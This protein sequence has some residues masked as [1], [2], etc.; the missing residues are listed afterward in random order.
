MKLVRIVIGMMLLVCLIAT[1]AW[2]QQSTTGPVPPPGID[3]GLQLLKPMQQ[4]IISGVPAYLWHHGCGPTAVGMVMGYWDGHGY[5]DLIPGDASAQTAAVDAMIAD[6]SG[7]PLCGGAT[8]DHYQDYSCPLDYSP[9]PL[10][11]DRSE[12]GGAHA[13]DCV[14]DFMLTSRSAR[15]NYYGW[16]WFS[17]VPGSFIDYVNLADPGTNPQADNFM[18]SQFSWQDYKE[19]IDNGRPVVLLVDTDGDGATDHFVTGIGYDD[20]AIE[21]AIYDTWDAQ[22]HWFAWRQ[23]GVGDTWGIYGVTTFHYDLCDCGVWG[24]VN[25]EG[26]LNPLDVTLMVQLVYYSND[27]RTQPPNCPLE[28]GDINCD[29][30]IDPIDVVYYIQWVYYDNNMSCPDPCLE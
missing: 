30:W 18:Y 6:D 21:Y 14:A 3:R 15:S 7:T 25:A 23:I 8:S 13:D 19:E 5:P 10:Q 12:T 11:P 20:V 2:A 29:G 16:S 1:S 28:A 24:D 26:H 9:D 17:D 22:I 27:L 4:V